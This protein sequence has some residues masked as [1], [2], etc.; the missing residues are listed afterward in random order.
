MCEQSCFN[1]VHRKGFM[2]T[3]RKMSMGGM[4]VDLKAFIESNYGEK[5]VKEES[6]KEFGRACIEFKSKKKEWSVS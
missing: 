5:I 3:N 1:C 6:L 4:M 2:C